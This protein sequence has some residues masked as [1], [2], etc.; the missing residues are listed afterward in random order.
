MVR[1]KQALGGWRFLP[2]DQLKPIKKPIKRS[3]TKSKLDLINP[4]NWFIG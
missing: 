3:H 2:D 1:V 4:A